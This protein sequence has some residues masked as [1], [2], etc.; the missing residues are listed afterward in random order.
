MRIGLA[1]P[2][3]QK[4]APSI[5]F[6]HVNEPQKILAEGIHAIRVSASPN[7]PL[8]ILLYKIYI[9]C[10]CSNQ[11]AP[12][13]P[14]KNTATLLFFFGNPFESNPV[15]N[16]RR[17]SLWI[18]S[19]SVLLAC[20]TLYYT[21]KPKDIFQAINNAD[22]ESLCRILEK[23]PGLVNLRDDR[24][25]LPLHLAIQSCNQEAAKMLIFYGADIKAKLYNG[26]PSIHFAVHCEQ[27]K[28]LG[29]LLANGAN[30]NLPN[31]ENV[32]PLMMAAKLGYK[33]A[34]TMLLLTNAEINVMDNNDRT[35]LDLAIEYGHSKIAKKLI[36]H[37]AKRGPHQE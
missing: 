5:V 23:D 3:Y 18:I 16:M 15:R 6:N 12:S 30:G 36:K 26:N 33:N 29:V 21:T 17:R 9:I 7:I 11:Q 14:K 27:N 35:P 20:G 37:G 8:D 2:G 10:K 4:K 22:L 19:I 24:G 28:M 13:F 31:K 32:T 34:V 25:I 1:P